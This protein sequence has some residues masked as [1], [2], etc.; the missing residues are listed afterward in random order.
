MQ[1]VNLYAIRVIEM[2]QFTKLPVVL[3][4]FYL[5]KAYLVLDGHFSQKV[6]TQFPPLG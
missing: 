6:S 3:C 5:Y 4:Y 1:I 2:F